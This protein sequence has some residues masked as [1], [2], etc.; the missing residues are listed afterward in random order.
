MLACKQLLQQ[1][2]L[3]HAYMLRPGFQQL[4]EQ[5]MLAYRQQL[6]EQRLYLLCS[7]FQQLLEQRMLVSGKLFQQW[8]L[9][10]QQLFQRLVLVVSRS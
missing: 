4:L 8:L 3:L 5:R 2:L 7:R 1:W 10:C 9:A 6:F